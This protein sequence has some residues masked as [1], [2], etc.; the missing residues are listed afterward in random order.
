[1][2]AA[3]FS[4]RR[5]WR[6]YANA[7]P[8]EIRIVVK[9]P[10]PQ[11]IPDWPGERRTFSIGFKLSLWKTLVWITLTAPCATGRKQARKMIVPEFFAAPGSQVRQF[12]STPQPPDIL[13]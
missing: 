11:M 13:P 4:R 1:M 12:D 2:I 5:Q 7:S 8:R 6:S 10:Q 3:S 9:I